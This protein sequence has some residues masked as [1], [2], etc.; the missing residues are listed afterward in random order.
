M[1]RAH[2]GNCT[3]RNSSMATRHKVGTPHVGHA[4]FQNN[5]EETKI[6]RKRK[7]TRTNGVGFWQTLIGLGVSV[8]V[9]ADAMTKIK[10]KHDLDMLEIII[11]GTD[12]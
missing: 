2:W 4:A 3:T 8:K 10:Q 1:S 9:P 11:C 12:E 6:P 5:G 7:R